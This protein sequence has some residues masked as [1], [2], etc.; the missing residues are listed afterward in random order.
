MNG[1]PLSL[2]DQLRARLRQAPA[3]SPSEAARVAEFDSAPTP[4]PCPEPGDDACTDGTPCAG[5]VKP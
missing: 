4:Y 3:L 5:C 2:R 1:R